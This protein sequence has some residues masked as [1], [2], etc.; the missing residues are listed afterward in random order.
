V[1]RSLTEFALPAKG[2]P[3]RMPSVAGP[4]SQRTF[5]ASDNM[6]GAEI[7]N[8]HETEQQETDAVA[9]RPSGRKRTGKTAPTTAWLADEYQ[10]KVLDLMV[11]NAFAALDYAQRL[12]GAKTPSEFVALSTSEACKQWGLMIKQADELGSI[13]QRL[14]TSDIKRPI[15]VEGK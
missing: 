8:V 1:R 11:T 12:I 9:P 5:T 2:A 15:V 3:A 7:T 13:A 6:H 10:A 14:A 4:Q